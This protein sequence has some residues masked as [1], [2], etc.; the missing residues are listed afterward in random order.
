M[1]NT[2][3]QLLVELLVN[4]D[5]F[6]GGMTKAA[7]AAKQFGNDL[8]GSFSG[9]TTQF[10]QL[11]NSIGLSFGPL[12]GVANIATN[13]ITSL[14]STIGKVGSGVPGIML[15]G[16]A[17]A[18]VGTA[19]VAA[20][21]AW[22]GLAIGGAHVVE[23]LEFTHEKLGISIA[24]LQTLKYAGEAVDVP[25]QTM[26][27][28]FRTFEKALADNSGHM[29]AAQI[30]LKNLGVTSK[31]PKEALLQVAD[32]ISKIEDPTV[33]AADASALFGSR[34]GLQLMPLLM[35]GRDGFVEYQRVTDEFAGHIDKNV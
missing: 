6:Q 27:R 4:T 33:R 30:A 5:A 10:S 12:S 16:A 11:G 15:T 3:G 23:E 19:A 2:I 25:L 32:A 17:V 26:V 22:A 9:L 21:A 18:S 28:G 7:G 20:A 13:A 29:S 8:K 24:D 14:A 35:K 34:M 1:S 31:D